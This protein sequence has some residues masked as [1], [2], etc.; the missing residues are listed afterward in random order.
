MPHA[1][2]K[3]EAS[4]ETAYLWDLLSDRLD[5][6]ANA[7]S[8]LGI[9]APDAIATGEQFAAHIAPEHRSAWRSSVLGAR[10]SAEATDGIAY[11]VQVAIEPGG[12]STAQRVWL[13][14]SGRWWPDATGRPARA[15][16][17]LRRIDDRDLEDRHL[18]GFVPDD[19]AREGLSRARLFEALG[20]HL[21]RA[22]RTGH[23]CGL[24][25]ISAIGL[26]AVNTRLGPDV[27]DELISAVGRL[28][29][30][31]L[32]ETA[33]VLRYASN[34]FAIILDACDAARL[35]ATGAQLIAHI[36]GARIETSSGPLKAAI[37]I[38]AVA[39]PGYA[40][41]A[42]D[43]V[44]RARAALERAKRAQRP[45]CVIHSNEDASP[46]QRETS[47]TREILAAL[48]ES[49]VLL[50]LQPIVDA[51]TGEA[52][53][54]E[55]LL[56]IRRRDGALIPA[57]DFI[58]EAE[59]LGLATPLDRRALDLALDLLVTYPRLRLCLNVSSLTAGNSDWIA[60][61]HAEAARHSGL[62]RRLTVEI[63]ETA[64]IHDL[65]AVRAFIDDLRTC[66]CKIA[67]DDFGAGYTSFRH[68]KT[69]PVDMLKIDGLFMKDLPNDPH[70]RIIVSSM[71][72][73]AK[74]LGI[75]T[76][77]EW[78]SDRETAALLAAAGATYLQGFLYRDPT[79][80]EDLAREGLLT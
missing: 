78:V 42:A 20:A 8:V 74:G 40:E 77:A 10:A 7:A 43:A 31:G 36:E 35:A 32:G 56:R 52:T 64:M 65:D 60:A 80:A 14:V 68:L 71:I 5:W 45:A 3:P 18:L 44:S 50:A 30:D 69:L 54:Y 37:A 76:V 51:A 75:E 63:T 48:E 61:L 2:T 22:Q 62:A 66:G 57:A 49:R 59:E 16:G 27:G 1:D 73:M 55:A 53:F 6:Q 24:L 58:E 47:S 11:R 70:G 21:K 4:R 79:P 9:A 46:Q 26:D 38:G 67:I 12:G 72:E 19:H 33:L 28:V 25:M 17:V 29:K 34:T 13:D 23:S 41:T 15:T 39:L